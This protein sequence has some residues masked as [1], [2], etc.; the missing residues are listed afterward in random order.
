MHFLPAVVEETSWLC[1]GMV[2]GPTVVL[3]KSRKGGWANCVR[4]RAQRG[5]VVLL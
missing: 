2:G 4:G 1:V 5:W 3:A